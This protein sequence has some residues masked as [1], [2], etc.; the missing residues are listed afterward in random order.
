MT[1]YQKSRKKVRG[2][3][4]SAWCAKKCGYAKSIVAQKAFGCTKKGAVAFWLWKAK[5]EIVR[6]YI[7]Q[8]PN[9]GRFGGRT[10]KMP[11]ARNTAF[12]LGAPSAGINTSLGKKVEE[13]EERRRGKREREAE[14][15]PS[16][17][18]ECTVAI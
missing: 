2:Y 12:R 15:Q 11:F 4:K 13:K 5:C 14:R 6:K 18:V 8:K 16:L 7:T 9:L 17:H 3:A 10:A 1:N